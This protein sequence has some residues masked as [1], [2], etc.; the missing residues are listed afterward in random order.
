MV[1]AMPVEKLAVP[2]LGSVAAHNG[3]PAQPR[4]P[5]GG[6]GRGLGIAFELVSPQ[7]SRQRQ[8]LFGDDLSIRG[9]GCRHHCA[10]VQKMPMPLGLGGE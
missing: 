6:R 10:L 8:G 5:H 4:L 9:R 1:V 7:T 3:A 2:G